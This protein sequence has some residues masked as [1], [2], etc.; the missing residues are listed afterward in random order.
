SPPPLERFRQLSGEIHA[1]NGCGSNYSHVHNRPIV[2]LGMALTKCR[3]CRKDVSTEATTCPHC[4]VPNP[5][6]PIH[7]TAASP[8]P[9]STPFSRPS[10]PPPTAPRRVEPAPRPVVAKQSPR[11][12]AAHG[13][14]VIGA[15]A[16]V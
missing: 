6:A 4:G 14:I 9:S 1:D 7:P 2:I 5:I 8:S 12:T 10:T 11:F 15:L 3:E 16:V 13:L